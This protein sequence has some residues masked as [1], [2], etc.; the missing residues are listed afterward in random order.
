[1]AAMSFNH[2]AD[3]SGPGLRARLQPLRTPWRSFRRRLLHRP[4]STLAMSAAVIAGAAILTNAL[5]LQTERHPSPMFTSL[6]DP[7]PAVVAAPVEQATV[8]IP[9][10]PARPQAERKAEVR[11]SAP[12][13]GTGKPAP[14]RDDPQRTASIPAT[15]KDQMLAIIRDS[16]GENTQAELATD[17]MIRIQKAL[18]KAGYGPLSA[19]GS[20]GP[21][22]RAAIERFET[23]RKLPVKGEARGKTLRELARVSG[24]A[25]D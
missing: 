23:D 12:K 22:T 10:P 9:L 11:E 6:T 15:P 21:Q 16:A 18:V 19:S 2:L 4:G 25:L 17:R 8:A 7:K 24:M 1:M 20:F 14:Q 5:A 3:Y 13:P